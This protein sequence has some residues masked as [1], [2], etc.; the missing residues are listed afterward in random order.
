V[1][2][3]AVLVVPTWSFG[4]AFQES[5]GQ[6]VI[7]AEHLGSRMANAEDQLWLVVP[8]ED[9]GAGLF[10]GYRGTGFVQTLPDL[11]GVGS[12]PSSPTDGPTVEYEIE[13]STPGMYQLYLRGGGHDDASDS[14]YA[15]I[16]E[17]VDG[18]GGVNADWYRYTLDA[19]ED[20]SVN[21]WNGE[22]GFELTNPFGGDQPAVWQIEATGQYTI[23]LDMREDG[24]AVDAL[25]LQLAAL[26]APSGIGPPESLSCTAG[27]NEV[28]WVQSAAG[29]WSDPQN[30]C[31]QSV[32]NENTV[33]LLYLDGAAEAIVDSDATASEV[34]VASDSAASDR[35]LLLERES[36]L[37]ADLLHVGQPDSSS[38]MSHGIVQQETNSVVMVEALELFGGAGGSAHYSLADGASLTTSTLQVNGGYSH[39][40]GEARLSQLGG[41]VSVENASISGPG[42]LQLYELIKGDA[43]FADTLQIGVNSLSPSLGTFIFD[44]GN[45]KTN[46]VEIGRGDDPNGL[47]VQS[48]G[49]HECSGELLIGRDLFGG[50]G[51]PD[52]DGLYMQ[53]G[54]TLTTNSVI[55]GAGSGSGGFGKIVI[56]GLWINSGNITAGDSAFGL[57]EVVGGGQLS[58]NTIV[59]NPDDDASGRVVVDGDGSELVVDS[60]V[61]L[62]GF[63]TS[64]IEITNG[65]EVNSVGAVVGRPCYASSAL[66]RATVRGQ[67]SRWICNGTFEAGPG[68]SSHP[69][70]PSESRFDVDSGGE[71]EADTI[72]LWPDLDVFLDE[73]TLDGEVRSV[74]TLN[75]G[76]SSES[77]IITLGTLHI[78]GTFNQESLLWPSNCNSGVDSTPLGTLVLELDGTIPDVEHDLVSITGELFGGGNLEIVLVDGFAPRLGDAF[79]VVTYGSLIAPFDLAVLP[80]LPD[81]LVM[82]VRYVSEGGVAGGAGSVVVSV[83]SLSSVLGLADP[84]NTPVGGS[85]IAVIEWD[86]DLDG[87]LDVALALQGENAQSPGSVLILR[88]AGNGEFT[89]GTTQFAAGLEPSDLVVGFFDAN[90]LPDLAVT[91]EGDDS[92]SILFNSGLIEG[93]L[94]FTEV[95]LVEAGESPKALA[96]GDF[97]GG[98][99]PLEL[100]V[101]VQDIAI[102]AAVS[103]GAGV[104]NVFAN[105]GAGRFTLIT[106]EEAGDDPVDIDPADVDNDK[107]LDLVVVTHQTVQP[108]GQ[109]S[110][111]V[112]GVLAYENLDGG[113][114]FSDPVFQSAG[115]LAS[116]FLQG[117]DDNSGFDLNADGFLDVVMTNTQQGSLTIMLNQGDGTLGGALQ[118]PL[119]GVPL[120]AAGADL[121]L[122][123]DIDL[124]IVVDQGEDGHELV[125][126]Q[127]TLN[128][129]DGGIQ[130]GFQE[131]PDVPST[132][133]PLLVTAGD[134]NGDQLDDLIVINEEIEGGIAGGTTSTMSSIINTSGVRICTADLFPVGEGDGI[135]S[136]GD[137]AELLANWGPCLG[138]DADIFPPSSGGDG[139]VS[140]GD[141]AELLA[142]WGSCK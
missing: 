27:P 49:L 123:Q 34:Y 14:V 138:C 101:S 131:F 29:S 125:V 133:A 4:G 57:I 24:C 75:P 83:E 92:V 26:P 21:P 64:V 84:L 118:Q 55:V 50:G 103:S 130:L 88:N 39:A 95:V 98:V 99:T 117:D 30:W 11:G 137:L 109:G 12:P 102:V 46:V 76:V 16:V 87:D 61:D 140:P 59:L 100:G 90:E 70:G 89:Q 15:R 20:F 139:V 35:K 119:A 65:G 33:A 37:S 18:G 141:L 23:Q 77:S 6:V 82:V 53:L 25:I 132:E 129:L 78:D 32:P 17:L 136:P 67:G 134:V 116:S 62:G 86:L 69:L 48:G 108:P 40:P 2:V 85:P 58:T 36:V 107:D 120:S 28:H 54:G 115:G 43:T 3:T 142:Q 105:D 5:G 111:Q 63:L 19:D 73:A 80:P 38:I 97:D 135:V 110:T 126:L 113:I 45:L 8:F 72:I 22:G 93:D 74:C 10:F 81:G 121:D 41:V 7:E 1:S 66:G 112:A 94:E 51:G 31:P 68:G 52:P 60:A 9:P 91:N 104:L 124:A 128:P 127:N 106:S 114:V 47:F 56:H 42:K 71:I 122:D 44:G 79:E 96:A 13:I